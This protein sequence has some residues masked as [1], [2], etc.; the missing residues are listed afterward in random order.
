MWPAR[1]GPSGSSLSGDSITDGVGSTPGTATS[2]PNDVAA[3]LISPHGDEVAVA[4]AGIAS[5]RLLSDVSPGIN[6][7]GLARADRDVFALP[8]VHRVILALGINDL[9]AAGAS[10]DPTPAD[11]LAG[12]RQF[13]ERARERRIA[14]TGATIT[15]AAMFP[16]AFEAKREAINAAIRAG[17]IFDD[18]VDF[19]AAV[20]DPTDRSR[21]SPAYDS[22]DHIHPNTA[23]YRAMADAVVALPS[24]ATRTDRG[25]KPRRAR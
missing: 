12:Y 11:I 2:W 16:P 17:G 1:S 14:V 18:V 15:P 22:G 8:G 7:S 5:G 19:D 9:A 6:Q 24:M 4:D 20:R 10:A 21:L 23:G 3:S 13:V 25:S